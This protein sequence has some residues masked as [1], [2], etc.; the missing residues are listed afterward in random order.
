[1]TTMTKMT[2]MQCFKK[3]LKL[4]VASAHIFEAWQ[5]PSCRHKLTIAASIKHLLLENLFNSVMKLVRWG[6]GVFWND[7]KGLIGNVEAITDKQTLSL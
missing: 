7:L 5:H 3:R 4:S 2:M 1:M 6:V